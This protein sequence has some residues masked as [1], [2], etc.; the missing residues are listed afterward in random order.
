MAP[1]VITKT[2]Y[3]FLIDYYCLGVLIYELVVG[4][5]PFIFTNNS[6]LFTKILTR[7]VYFPGHLSSKCRSFLSG[8]L[9]KNPKN[10]LGA[11]EGLTEI[12]N[13][14]WLCDMNF[15][16]IM[17]KKIKPPIRPDPYSLNFAKDFT[18]VKIGTNC[19]LNASE[20]QGKPLKN[21]TN[22]EAARMRFANFSFYS[23]NEAPDKYVDSLLHTPIGSPRNMAF[24]QTGA[25]MKGANADIIFNDYLNKKVTMHSFLIGVT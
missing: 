4:A 25:M 23:N 1:E 24:E 22:K 20:P 19:D 2:G 12:V 11:K 8:L 14:P 3:N 5:P 10:R 13:H 21:M 15:G 17:M 7:D 9:K 16:Q 18:D 6:D